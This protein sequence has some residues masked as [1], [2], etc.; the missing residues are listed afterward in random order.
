MI[1]QIETVVD[2]TSCDREPIHTPGAIL[3]H[4]AMLVVDPATMLI[5]QI[6]GDTIGLLGKDAAALAGQ[7]LGTIFSA[8]QVARLQDL[9][10]GP[11]LVRP[12]HLLDPAMRVV[13]SRP[14]DASVHL[15]NEALV[16][17]VE[18]ADLADRHAGD[19]LACVQEMFDGLGDAPDL[20]SCCQLAADR[21]RAVAGYDR[22]MVYRFM[23][24][25]SGWVFAEARRHDIAPFL[26]LHYPASDIPK[27][28]RALYLTSWLRLITEVDYSAAHV[29]FLLKGPDVT[30]APKAALALSLAIHELAT[31]AAK[32]GAL[33]VATGHVDVTWQIGPDRG[34]IIDWQE[35]GGPPVSKPSRRGFGST[36][37]ERALAMETG[38]GSTLSF[39]PSGVTC[40]ITLPASAVLGASAE[41]V[42]IMGHSEA[43]DVAP[44]LGN[45]VRRILIVE[46]TA[47]VV[48]LLEDVIANLGWEVV[49]P[50]TRLEQAVRL[51]RA[52]EIDAVV[53]DINLDGEMSWPVAAILQDG[54][55]PFVFATGY[56]GATVIPEQFAGH[57]VVRKP[58][59][60]ADIERVLRELLSGHQSPI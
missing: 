13:A 28:A 44:K 47:M 36:L 14:I 55:I 40:A 22:V 39:E 3:P 33:S 49:G 6:A 7:G 25:D 52:G 42:A 46:D 41:V 9:L 5:D 23:P 11:R 58:Y 27:Q 50:A 59:S 21:V 53:L 48:M 51:A 2:L 1:D 31:N 35:R 16:I 45:R 24:D 30:V 60:M 37:I 57:P 15:S 8:E 56:D 34:L 19:P 43:D 54:R 32:Y 12:R 29:N 26:D 4:G 10:Q 20:E 18:D 38:G 17:E